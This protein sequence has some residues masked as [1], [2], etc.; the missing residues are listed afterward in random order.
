MKIGSKLILSFL[1][2]TFLPTLL[3]AFLTTN[4]INSSK[5]HDAQETINNNLKAAWMQYY[6]RAYQMQY[7]MLQASTEEFIKE[8]IRKKDKPLLK[9][10][11]AA[12]KIHRPYVDLWAV[13]DANSA[14]I[15]SNNTQESGY[16]ITLGGLVRKAITE[17]ASFISTEL[18]PGDILAI[19][20]IGQDARVVRTVEENGRRSAQELREG[21]MLVVVTPVAD[22]GGRVVG[23]IVTGDLIN[24]DTFVPDTFAESIPGSLVTISMGDVQVATNVMDESGKRLIGHVI[25][26]DVLA[27][28]KSHMGYRGETVIAHK[29]YIS[30]F[31][32]IINYQAKIIGS[33]FVGVPQERFVNLQYE[34]IKAVITISMIGL[35]LASGAASFVTYIITRPIHSLKKKAQLVTSGDLNVRMGPVREGNDEIGDLARTFETMLQSLRDKEERIKVSQEELATQ[36]ILIESIINS[37]PYCLYVLDREKKIILCNTHAVEACHICR[38]VH[39]DDEC[40]S[41]NLLAQLPSEDLKAGLG[42]AVN[43]VFQ[44]G[45][46]QSLEYSLPGDDGRDKVIFTSVFPVHSLSE[47]SAGYVVWMSEDITRKKEL[48]SNIISSEKLAAVG[49]LAAGIAHEVNNPLGGILNC[50][51]NFKNKKLTEERKAEYIDFMEDGIRRVQNIIRQLLDF[52]QQHTPELKLLDVNAMIEGIIPLFVHSVKG[53]D[54]S[55]TTQLG[56]NLPPI[57]AD[58]H[59]IEQIVV[60]L[61][62]NAVQALTG[63]GV[64]EVKTCVDGSWFCLSVA[65]NGCGISKDNLNRVFDPFFTTKGV[66][67]GTGLGLSVS[68]G[69]IERHKGRI[70]VDSQPGKGS[71]FKV[72]LPLP[73]S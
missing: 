36:N 28:I 35:F 17:N 22:R 49:Q 19:E 65:D 2:V 57:M 7:G 15:A 20:K 18:V 24:N 25:P 9:R 34:N 47:G 41:S 30:A 70:E 33:I 59:Q 60:N 63:G 38:G 37:L 4:L 27:G 14:V 13:V 64:I 68:R 62:L 6:A 73:L 8:A 45:V 71:T 39:K 72:Y 55:L 1:L 5:K 44:T 58:K 66:G 32:P 26:S 51:Y 12:W 69:I 23:A 46:P 29:P 56:P 50:L 53:R 16:R 42:E 43:K 11:L 67:K 40:Y 61:I 48:E 3:L 21:M 10:Q 54:I 31:D 52:S